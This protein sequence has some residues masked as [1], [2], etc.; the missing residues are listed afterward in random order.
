MKYSN[1]ELSKTSDGY[2]I[3]KE[4]YISQGGKPSQKSNKT[5][6]L[7]ETMISTLT[8]L[9]VSLPPEEEL[10]DILFNEWRIEVG[11]EVKRLK[12]TGFGKKD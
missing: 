4:H 9:G 10:K 11:K 12:G 2:Y 8:K 1:Y 3:Y 5:Y 6:L 7:L